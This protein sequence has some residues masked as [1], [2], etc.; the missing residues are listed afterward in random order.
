MHSLGHIHMNGSLAIIYVVN[1]SSAA[2]AVVSSTTTSVVC[3]NGLLIEADT[4]SSCLGKVI[5]LTGEAWNELD[6]A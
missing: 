2:V 6:R 3:H 5:V 4:V 1:D